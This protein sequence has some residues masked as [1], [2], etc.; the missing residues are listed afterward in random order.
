MR[1]SIFAALVAAFVTLS[2]PAFGQ[3]PDNPGQTPPTQGEVIAAPTAPLPGTTV[4][5]GAPPAQGDESVPLRAG[6]IR[7][8]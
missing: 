2:G 6:S 4:E 1:I 8:I 7:S 3:V 5:I